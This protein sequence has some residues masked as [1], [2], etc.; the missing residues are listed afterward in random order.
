MGL[1]A[2]P[3]AAAPVFGI[4]A[5][6]GVTDEMQTDHLWHA[7]RDRR[8][9]EAIHRAMGI[10]VAD[11][12]GQAGPCRDRRNCLTDPLE[13]GRVTQR[14]LHEVVVAGRCNRHREVVVV[15]RERADGVVRELHRHHAFGGRPRTLRTKPI[16]TREVD[17]SRV[18]QLVR[19]LR[20]RGTQL[21]GEIAAPP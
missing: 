6:R 11:R 16:V 7:G 20:A 5:H 12:I 13:R 21:C 18:V 3:R 9:P 19:D 17:H 1:F 2:A 8:A 4:R 15:C 14:P 10:D